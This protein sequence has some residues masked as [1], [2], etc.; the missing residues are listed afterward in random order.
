MNQQPGALWTADRVIDILRSLAREEDRPNHLV[1]GKITGADTIETLGIDSI[2]A[3]ALGDR[4]EGEAGV[5]LPD[6][7][8]DVVD[9]IDDIVQRLN[10][11]K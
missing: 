11:L 9:K 7:L 10:S 8:L 6:G 3:V 5:L 1:E 4:L 2:G